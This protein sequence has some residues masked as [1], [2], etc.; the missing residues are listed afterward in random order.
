MARADRDTAPP[1]GERDPD[2]LTDEE[3]AAPDRLDADAGIIRLLAAAGVLPGQQLGGRWLFQWPAVSAAIAEHGIDVRDFLT[4]EQL[5]APDRLGLDVQ[6]VR[7]L[8][9]AGELQGIQAGRRW[10]FRW[11]AIYTL[12]AGPGV[13][14]GE[15]LSASQLARRF[16]VPVRAVQ[17]AAA[18]PGTPGKLPGRRIGKKWRFAWEAVRQQLGGDT[19]S[20]GG[21]GPASLPESAQPGG[22]PG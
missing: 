19:A 22:S 21:P 8:A 11:T 9:A 17:R 2:F 14:P 1:A 3:L 18:P 6:T 13:P 7:D 15:V 10:L 16:G 20:T 12:I 4:A 5:A